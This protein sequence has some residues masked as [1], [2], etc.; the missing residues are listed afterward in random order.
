VR[1]AYGKFPRCYFNKKLQKILIDH[2]EQLLP[3][4]QDEKKAIQRLCQGLWRFRLKQ[5][6]KK[7]KNYIRDPKSTKYGLLS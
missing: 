2:R 6:E 5:I 1:K 3:I 4:Y 7:T